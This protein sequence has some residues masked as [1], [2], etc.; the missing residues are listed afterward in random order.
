MPTAAK[1]VAAILTAALG[2]FVADV[3]I[4]HLPEQDRD[5]WMREVSAFLGLIIGWRFL[6]WRI[7]GGYSQALGLGLSTSLVLFV[8]GAVVFAG[9]EMLIRSL[10]KSY[11]GPVEA[12]EGMV[13]IAVENL[14]YV[15]HADVIATFVIGGFIVGLLTE[16]AARR[17][18]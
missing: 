9:Y 18:S 17:W 6:G 8:T 1:L 11:D 10:R 3:I 15:Q 4:P 13:G 5:N 12:I 7:G 2:Y 14:E 16:M